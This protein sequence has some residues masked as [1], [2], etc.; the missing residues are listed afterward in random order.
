M[1]RTRALTR[2]AY[3][4]GYDVALQIDGDG[5]HPA[6]EAHRLLERLARGDVD[7]VIG[8]RFLDGDRYGQTRAPGKVRTR[9]EP[10]GAASGT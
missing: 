9:P 5:Q 2:Y 6:H 3:H 4:D 7:M 10:D 8:S 1:S